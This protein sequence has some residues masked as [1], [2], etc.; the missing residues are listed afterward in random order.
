V[1]QDDNCIWLDD[2]HRFVHEDNCQSENREEF[3]C[4][5]IVNDA[6]YNKG[7]MKNMLSQ[8]SENLFEF[9][10]LCG[11]HVIFTVL[12]VIFSESLSAL[13][14]RDQVQYHISNL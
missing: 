5:C 3:S 6:H 7:R 9:N 12:I 10:L 4:A 2:L 14:V 8:V 1:H 11:I 13:R